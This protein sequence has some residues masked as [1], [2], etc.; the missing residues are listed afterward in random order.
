[1]GGHEHPLVDQQ[2]ILCVLCREYGSEDRD[3]F[4]WE[5]R[6]PICTHCMVER[7]DDDEAVL[8]L[9][10]AAAMDRMHREAERD[11]G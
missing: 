3:E 9:G 4:D 6:V 1:M 11:D 5:Q 2:I 7:A 10:F 8:N